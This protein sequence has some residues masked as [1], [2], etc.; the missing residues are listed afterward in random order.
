[1]WHVF[2]IAYW[3]NL[4]NHCDLLNVGFSEA[5]LSL[6]SLHST[7]KWHEGAVG[8]AWPKMNLARFYLNFKKNQLK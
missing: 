2:I 4:T 8:E 3:V 5:L 7:L 1:M 6:G